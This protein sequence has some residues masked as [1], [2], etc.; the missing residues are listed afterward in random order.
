M[1]CNGAREGIRTHQPTDY[2][3]VALPLR[4]SGLSPVGTIQMTPVFR[5]GARIQVWSGPSAVSRDRARRHPARRCYHSAV[6]DNPLRSLPSVD[7]LLAHPLLR[8]HAALDPAGAADAVRAVLDDA[9]RQFAEGEPLPAIDALAGDA[10]GALAAGS[11][12][13]P[14]R[15]INA[16]GVVIHTNLGRA[17]LSGAALAAMRD[18]AFDYAGLEFDLDS[19]ER[20]SRHV[21]VEALLCRV[22]GAEAAIV[23]N[24]AAAAV[25]LALTAFARDREVIV[26]RGQA[27]EIG[28]GFRIPDVLRQSGARLVEAGTTNRTYGRD[29]DDAITPE[30]AALLRVHHSNFR[31]IGFT[32]EPT[33]A[34]L[35][36]IGQRRGVMVLDDLGSGC[37]LDTT[38]F[39]LTAEPRVQDSVAAGAD[40][41]FFS[42]DKLLGGPQA[43]II[44][45]KAAPVATLRRHPLVRALRPGKA[46]IAALAATLAHY[47]HGEALTAIPVWRMI[48]AEPAT[49]RRRARRLARAIGEGATTR[50]SRSMIGGGSLPEEGLPTTVVELPA[51]AGRSPQTVAAALRACDPPIVARIEAGRVLL[52]PRT[53]PARDDALVAR[54]VRTAVAALG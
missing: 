52:D 42:G 26:S 4:H 17:P 7:R 54:R 6:N 9:R 8:P 24:N 29:Y 20:G 30:T 32:A 47:A 51:V 41:V 31:I 11:R 43:G 23:V 22:T 3:S 44:A 35:V 28:G 50:P 13:G 5:V 2:K 15:V 40:L 21:H 39:G 25:L 19:G 33:L 49:L 14:A 46:T 37:L 45:G 12:I 53:V 34:E 16:T 10:A 1:V 36:E 38:A 48:A 18:A 27:I